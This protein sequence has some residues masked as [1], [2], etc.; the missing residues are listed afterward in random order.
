VSKVV[1]QGGVS[2]GGV[3]GNDFARLESLV[4]RMVTNIDHLVLG[5]HSK[6]PHI[7]PG[8]PVTLGEELTGNDTSKGKGGKN[9]N[10]SPIHNY[11]ACQSSP[12]TQSPNHYQLPNNY[13][14]QLQPPTY[15]NQPP[16]YNHQQPNYNHQLQPN[17]NQ[18]QPNYNNNQPPS[19]SHN[20]LHNY[21]HNNVIMQPSQH[22]SL[23]HY[24]AIVAQQDAERL[25]T[26]IR[27]SF[28]Y[29]H[30][31]YYTPK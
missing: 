20:Y 13:N 18:Q 9:S 31:G 15:N 27:N 11:S 7:I 2:H 14:N 6:G 28:I 17:Y 3:A 16:S 12:N 23:L 29:Q 24:H 19:P 8:Q 26:D 22:N 21:P 25:R 5:N 10:K 1:N 4:A 30:T